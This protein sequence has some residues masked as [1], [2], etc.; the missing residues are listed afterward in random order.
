M[1]PSQANCSLP[2]SRTERD[3]S[4]HT[5]EGLTWGTYVGP[6]PQD[7]MRINWGTGLKLKL[8]SWW[9]Y[10][11]ANLYPM[12]RLASLTHLLRSLPQLI[13]SIRIFISGS[14]SRT[15]YKITSY[16]RHSANLCGLTEWMNEV[17]LFSVHHKSFRQSLRMSHVVFR[18]Y[19]VLGIF[20]SKYYEYVCKLA[21]F[22]LF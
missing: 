20:P 9:D 8:M 18:N 2:F 4:S 1:S 3:W 16:R 17:N 19:Y 22:C 6:F 12:C 5:L 10:I 15:W 21:S 7:G 13:I 11:L 14:A